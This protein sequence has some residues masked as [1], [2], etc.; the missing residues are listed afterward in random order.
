MKYLI[1]SIGVFAAFFSS[2]NVFTLTGAQTEIGFNNYAGATPLPP[3]VT[4]AR[5]PSGN[6][7]SGESATLYGTGFTSDMNVQFFDVATN[8]YTMSANITTVNN[9]DMN[10]DLPS[11]V[12]NNVNLGVHVTS[13][14]GESKAY[15]FFCGV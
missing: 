14:N 6:C 1:L 9:T 5:V 4:S 2:C 13:P 11:D 15:A 3:I 8:V 12:P 7:V 10:V